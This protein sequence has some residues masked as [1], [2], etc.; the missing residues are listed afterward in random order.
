MVPGAKAGVSVRSEVPSL[1]ASALS[2]A[3][4]EAPAFGVTSTSAA[5]ALSL[6]ASAARSWNVWSVSLVRFGTVK[7]PS[8][9]SPGPLSSISIQSP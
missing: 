9:V 2:V 4:L 3:S 5:A 6:S 7:P 8:L 1:T